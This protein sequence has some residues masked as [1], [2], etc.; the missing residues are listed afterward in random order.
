MSKDSSDVKEYETT[1]KVLFWSILLLFAIFI[2]VML[3]PCIK[4]IFSFLTGVQTKSELLKFIGWGISGLIA[5]LGV[6]GLLKRTN[7]LDEQN[8][9]TEKGH[10]HERFKAATEHLGNKDSVSMRIASFN[11]FYSLAEITAKITEDKGLKET[12]FDILCAH[13]RQTTKHKDYQHNLKPTEEM[14]NLLAILFKPKNK[15]IFSGLNVNL[16][17]THLKGAYLQYAKLQ[18]ANLENAE[19]KNA[20]LENAELKNAYLENTELQNANLENANLRFINLQNA[21][22]QN[23]NLKN[24]EL[25]GANLQGINLQNADMKGAKINQVAMNNMPSNWKKVV[26][27]YKGKDGK[28]KTGA[29]LVDDKGTV[30]EDL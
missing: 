30:T 10:I 4:C 22:L 9:L 8:K 19:L 2:L 25:Q 26:K 7:A 28:E 14:Q 29:F 17:E 6:I 18:Y 23:A 13:V 16:A 20:Y 3:F 12:I 1:R 5:T 27:Q 15:D 21:K 11:E 24:T